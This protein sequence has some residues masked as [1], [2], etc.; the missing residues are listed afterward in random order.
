MDIAKVYD[1]EP[2]FHFPIDFKPILIKQD[3]KVEELKK[4]ETDS[5]NVASLETI[6]RNIQIKEET[7]NTPKARSYDWDNSEIAKCY[8]SS[9]KPPNPFAMLKADYVYQEEPFDISGFNLFDKR[10]KLKS[11]TENVCSSKLTNRI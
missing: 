3:F 10:K 6:I 9:R 8:R 1:R 2:G 11:S 5:E 4:C 7:T